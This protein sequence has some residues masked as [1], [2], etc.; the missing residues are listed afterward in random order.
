MKLSTI[1]YAL[2]L[3]AV[4][5][6]S[7]EAGRRHEQRQ[8]KEPRVYCRIIEAQVETVRFAF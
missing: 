5:I 3:V 7:F 6:V 8:P 4:L 2:L 1:L